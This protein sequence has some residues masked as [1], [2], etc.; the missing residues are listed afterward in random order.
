VGHQPSG[1]KVA[2][3][4]RCGRSYGLVTMARSRMAHP[5]RVLSHFAPLLQT[6][7]V[8]KNNGRVI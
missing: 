3:A 8:N 7:N 1:S 5:T 2:A 4:V 6:C